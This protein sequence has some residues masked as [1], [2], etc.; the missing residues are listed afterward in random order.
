MPII[1]YASLLKGAA[2]AATVHN[3]PVENSHSCSN[4][5]ANFNAQVQTAQANAA[6][7]QANSQGT[8]VET[9]N[10]ATN[11]SNTFVS[12]SFPLP[13]SH[14][15]A[16]ES[17]QAANNTALLSQLRYSVDEVASK[18]P[19]S[20]LKVQIYTPDSHG[21]ITDD[22][23]RCKQCNIS[24]IG[25]NESCM[26]VKQLLIEGHEFELREKTR[27]FVPLR[28]EEAPEKLSALEEKFSSEHDVE[29]EFKTHQFDQQLASSP[30]FD[31]LG[32]R[33]N[34]DKCTMKLTVKLDELSGNS[35]EILS[36]PSAR[37]QLITAVLGP[38][39]RKVLNVMLEHQVKISVNAFE[40]V[41]FAMA[42]QPENGTLKAKN[43]VMISSSSSSSC[44]SALAAL[45]QELSDRNCSS[46][47]SRTIC[48]AKA[49]GESL[50]LRELANMHEIAFKFG[51][52][53]EISQQQSQ[54]T[55]ISVHGTHLFLINS[56]VDEICAILNEYHSCTLILE[57]EPQNLHYDMS[58]FDSFECVPT[59]LRI[60]SQR[61]ETEI[62]AVSN[63]ITVFGKEA[64]IANAL[65]Y[66]KKL[67]LVQ[68]HLKEC[69]YEIQKPHDIREFICGK[70]DGKINKIVK[71]TGVN[72]E[73][74]NHNERFLSIKLNC[75]S[76]AQI[77]QTLTLLNGE[78]P[79]EISF[80]VPE[81]HHKRI[82]GH[83]G[84]NIQRIMKKY[85]VYIKFLNFDECVSRNGHPSVTWHAHST[86]IFPNVIVKTPFKNR[87]VLPDMKREVLQEA[88]EEEILLKVHQFALPFNKEC[89]LNARFCQEISALSMEYSVDFFL[90]ACASNLLVKGIGAEVAKVL[91]RLANA[92]PVDCVA[93]EKPSSSVFACERLQKV[94]CYF[95]KQLETSIAKKN[96]LLI[97]STSCSATTTTGNS[98]PINS[99]LSSPTRQSIPSLLAES[100]MLNPVS[101]PTTAFKGFENLLFSDS[102][103][104][105][106][107]GA[108]G[109]L[110]EG[111]CSA[112]VNNSSNSAAA[113]STDKKPPPGLIVGP[114]KKGLSFWSAPFDVAAATAALN[115][116]SHAS[117][118]TLEALLES[119]D[120]A[121]YLQN[122]HSH[123][124]DYASLPH[125]TDAD[126]KE[127][128]IFALGA[129][130]RLLQA[131][132]QVHCTE[133]ATASG[134]PLTKSNS[135]ISLPSE[136]LFFGHNGSEMTGGGHI[137]FLNYTASTTGMDFNSG[138]T[139]LF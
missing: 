81:F 55:S 122:F 18:V 4:E 24:I 30:Y 58:E 104:T 109:G 115:A 52:Y 65:E 108:D 107:K 79:A 110:F 98:I 103:S 99:K 60:I 2:A 46:I 136:R 63:N 23:I 67:K 8:A 11:N 47:T 114:K 85:G 138:H 132:K 127:I 10:F 3:S 96:D 62:I 86:K 101:M 124:I 131:F 113:N 15:N 72:I 93:F 88:N 13:S 61:T 119:I 120:L 48:C 87:E 116:S 68:N 112:V 69:I 40:L 50:L 78:F 16:E 44:K 111:L 19:D 56:A 54:E 27:L 126:L 42:Q 100:S 128:G 105:S 26:R 6:S 91:E 25:Q 29:L 130:K 66:L 22:G 70:K 21:T 36:V 35:I 123:E 31:I 1:S 43:E 82:I 34:I 135:L 51:V 45:K 83:G 89:F 49:K 28:L 38:Q 5:A 129:R 74:T 102:L 14:A 118:A 57:D 53:I 139:I 106:V 94:N 137:N 117:E 125:L 97:L 41:H 73:M 121:K 12:F 39:M 80:Y 64:N 71:E 92:L 33:Q 133:K 59:K 20:A 90:S 95:V 32:K 37:P 75:E 17:E 77:P 76:V 7:N 9:N 134:I 84:K